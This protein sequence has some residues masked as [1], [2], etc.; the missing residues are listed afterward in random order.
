MPNS[1]RRS[2]FLARDEVLIEPGS[3]A[4]ASMVKQAGYELL[5]PVDAF[6]PLVAE[7]EANLRAAYLKSPKSAPS[8]SARQLDRNQNHRG[9][10]AGFCQPAGSTNHASTTRD[11]ISDQSRNGALSGLTGTVGA[12]QASD[13]EIEAPYG[14][15]LK[16]CSLYD[17]DCLRRS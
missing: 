10:Y 3:Q 17:I 15:F 1:L 14:G 12:I 9:P 13:A 7:T 4:R 11:Q 8:G 2:N 16:P 6:Q 5:G